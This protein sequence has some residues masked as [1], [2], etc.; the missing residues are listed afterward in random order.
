MKVGEEWRGDL[1]CMNILD[2]NSRRI[3]NNPVIDTVKQFRLHTEGNT[4]YI[5]Q[6]SRKENIFHDLQHFDMMNTKELLY[7]HPTN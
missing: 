6:I 5:F 4:I 7:H 3:A 2:S 1:H